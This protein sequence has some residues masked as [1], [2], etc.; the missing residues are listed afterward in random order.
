MG[1]ARAGLSRPIVL[2]HVPM[3]FALSG[4]LVAGSAFRVRSVKSFLALRGLRI[5]PAL[6]VEVVLS[7]L[8]IGAYATTLPLGSYFQDHGFFTYFGNIFGFVQMSLPGV[9]WPSSGERTAVNANLWTLPGEFYCYVILSIGMFSTLVFNRKVCTALFIATTVALIYA[10]IFRGFNSKAGAL[11]TDL[12][13][14][15]FFVGIM[16]FLWKDV[17]WR[18]WVL[19]A[20]SI[21]AVYFLIDRPWG[22]YLAPL[23]L[24]YVTVFI[25][26]IEFPSI[27]LLRS[28]DYSYGVYL[29]GFPISQMVLFEFP[30]LKGNY[31]ALMV[32]SLVLTILFAYFSW[33][34]IEKHFLKLKRHFTKSVPKSP[35]PQPSEEVT[36][37]PGSHSRV[38]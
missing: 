13:V 15:Y 6:G 35:P 26:L 14:Y 2:S 3:F 36:E 34:G 33:H 12:N 37:A 31:L 28:G 5:F 30:Q 1:L 22:I 4:F 18:S 8:L 17:I 29:Y 24:A 27:K 23:P 16:F 11:A 10:N 25:G 9:V 20:L 7:A 21:V 19:F 38:A 32:P